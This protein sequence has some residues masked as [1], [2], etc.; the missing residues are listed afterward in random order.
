MSSLLS[1]RGFNIRSLAVGETDNPGISRMT[2]IAECGPEESGQ[3]LAQ[4]RKL[5]CV[6]EAAIL[7]PAG[8]VSRELLMVK[9][10]AAAKTRS[11]IIEIAN[12]FR[13]RIV[14]VSNKSLTL[15]LTG[16]TDKTAAL[17][18]LLRGYGII[19]A[20]RTGVIALSRGERGVG[21]GA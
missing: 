5:E 2:I 4:I 3:I 17:L 10:G 9:I 21:G 19:E 7:E 13:A 11:E 14:D 15:E 8:C 6:R 1:R 12:I 20:A 16:E 18:E